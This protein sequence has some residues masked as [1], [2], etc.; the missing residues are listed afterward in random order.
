MHK[1]T[2][3]YCF[4]E[5]RHTFIFSHPDYTVGSGIT[6]DPALSA[7]GLKDHVHYRRSGISPRPEDEMI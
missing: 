5:R 3:S 6:P 2:F 4:F 7:R 1:E